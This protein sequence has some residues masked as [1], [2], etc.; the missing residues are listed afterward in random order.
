M[1]EPEMKQIATWIFEAISHWRDPERL[2]DIRQRVLAC[3][4]RF[5]LI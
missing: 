4:A 3:T 2:A 1:Q 5:P